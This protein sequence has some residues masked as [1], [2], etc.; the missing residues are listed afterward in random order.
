MT[1]LNK[2]EVD[3][4]ERQMRIKGFKQEKLKNATV[5]VVGSGG[6]GSPVLTYLAVAGV[7]RIIFADKDR[8]KLGNLNRQ[9][10]HW[11]GDIGKEKTDS[12]REKLEKINPNVDITAINTEIRDNNIDKKFNGVDI[13]IDALD[14][15]EGRFVLNEFCLMTDTPLIHGSVEG[16]EGR[17]TTIIPGET[18]C[19]RCIFPEVPQPSIFPVLGTTPGVIGSLQATEAIKYITGVGELFSNRL[20]V[21]DGMDL[22]FNVVQL[23]KNKNCPV[24][25]LLK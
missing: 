23:R 2:Y 12:A 5:G 17:L 1:V 6:L 7:G 13:M 4:Y 16:F 24:C 11:D 18:P 19:L 15:F 3:R 20:L 9:T 14:N 22:S 10:L 25:G 8:V 21:Y